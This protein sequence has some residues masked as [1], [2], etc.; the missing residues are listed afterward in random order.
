MRRGLA[1]RRPSLGG[2]SSRLIG[3]PA[4]K[5]SLRASG[6]W[7]RH[8]PSRGEASGRHRFKADAEG[9]ARPACAGQ[10]QFQAEA[11]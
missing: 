10:G 3:A 11:L 7:H 4:P 8:A 5:H 1:G 9:R 6:V 2:R